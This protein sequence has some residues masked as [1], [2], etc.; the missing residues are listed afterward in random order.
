LCRAATSRPT[1]DAYCR[2]GKDKSVGVRTRAVELLTA[3]E[4]FVFRGGFGRVR[5]AESL[6]ESVKARVCVD[7]PGL[8][9]LCFRLVDYLA[10]GATIVSVPHVCR[11][12]IPLEEGRQIVFCEPDLSDLV[13]V[14]DA[15][16]RD[17]AR[18]ERLGREAREY[19]QRALDYRQLTRYYLATLFERV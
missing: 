1:A 5:Y 15:L 18:T 6:V 19:F 3:Q 12:H 7:L 13:D 2:F 11:L 8:G 10:V 16:R 14:I 4:L 17:P 9:P